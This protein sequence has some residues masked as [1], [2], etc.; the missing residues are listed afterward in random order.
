MTCPVFIIFAGE[1]VI[2][3][4]V[5]IADADLVAAGKAASPI[6]PKFAPAP[7]DK[8][9]RTTIA[10]EAAAVVCEF[11]NVTASTLHP[12]VGAV[13]KVTNAPEPSEAVFAAAIVT[14]IVLATFVNIGVVLTA[15]GY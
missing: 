4:V 8:N 3:T 1:N 15:I 11:L 9:T 13:I 2:V 12:S 7:S 14:G 5:P 10:V 6:N